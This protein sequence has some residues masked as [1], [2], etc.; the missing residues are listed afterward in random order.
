MTTRPPPPHY[1]R[2]A[3]GALC[4]ALRLDVAHGLCDSV[5]AAL[6]V[7]AHELEA[8]AL[9]DANA[10]AVAGETE[11]GRCVIVLKRASATGRVVK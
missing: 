8:P 6:A 10:G 4:A 2:R 3:W 9:H 1:R 7:P 11:A 5:R